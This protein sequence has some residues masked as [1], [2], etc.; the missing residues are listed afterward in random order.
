MLRHLMSPTKIG[1]LELRNRI[2]MAPMGV[3]IVEAD[4]KVREPTLRYYAERARGGAGLLI[5]ENTAACYPRGANSAH[6][7]GVSDDSFLPGLTSLAE[8]VHEHGAK[9]AI[10]LAHHGKVARLD[11]QQGRE[12]LMPSTPRAHSGPR[13][14]LDLT[15]EEMGLMA[16]A[17]G[18][19]RPVIHE[20]TEQD[21]LQLVDDFANAALRAKRAGFDAVEIHGAHGYI[22][23]EFHSRAWNF[24]EDQYGGSTENR[25]RLLCNVVRACREKL[26]IDFP[27]WCRID[28]V[29]FDTP[30]GITLEDSGRTA[31]LLEAA[32]ADAIHVSA[33]ANP[34]GAGFTEG[35]IVHRESGFIEF[36]AAIKQR[37]AVPVIVAGRIE[38]AAGDRWIREGKADLISMGRKLLADPELP[39]KLAED[40]AEDIRPCIYCYVCV[41][42]P[43]FDR[44]VRCAVN[45]LA[46]KELEY[47][48]LLRS[49]TDAKKRVLVV[50][51]GPAGLEAACIAATRGHDVVLCEKSAS[52]GGTLRFA[53]LPYEPNERLLHYLETRV[54]KLPVELRLSCEVT[55]ALVRELVPDIVLAA[56]GPCREKSKI[57]GADGDHVFDGD[58]LRDLLTGEGSSGAEQQLSI[59]GRV[60]VRAG[61]LAGVTS[62]PARLRQASK[63]YMPLGKRVAI[64][65]GGLVGIELAEFMAERGREVRVFDQGSVFAKEMAHPRRWRVLHDLREAGVELHGETK[66]LEIGSNSI[67]FEALGSDSEPQEWTLDNVV[68]ATGLAANPEGVE[69]LRSAGVPLVVIGDANGAGYLDGAIEQGF[70]A[71]LDLG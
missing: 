52:L 29:E 42:Q 26:G 45:P 43:F 55:P 21:L 36:A 50:G 14:P 40:R 8:A 27:L 53:A 16:K 4:G 57:P 6:E 44:T 28:A 51:A 60:A 56:V 65:G 1:T 69:A 23:S 71:A 63:V 11:T 17:A 18:G 70:K 30:D 13:G 19:S 64:V 12:L 15:G 54:R 5:T 37:V 59:A 48:E 32:G 22:F 7:I 47:A 58:T 49:K 46:A 67:R 61:R 41:A 62:D 3:E 2:A 9:I 20:A 35:P 68:I 34:L 39:L 38:P 10:Q 25:S 31:E 24:R 33:Y 66:V